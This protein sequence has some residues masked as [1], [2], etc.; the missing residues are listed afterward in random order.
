MGAPRKGEIVIRYTWAPDDGR[1]RR[2]YAERYT[3]N[4]DDLMALAPQAWKGAEASNTSD[5]ARNAV[6]AL[7][8]IAGNLG[9][10]NR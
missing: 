7:R 3:Y 2:Q 8:A 9:D 1:E 10:L 6:L 5:D 4:L